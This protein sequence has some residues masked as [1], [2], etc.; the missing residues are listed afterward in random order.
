M[1][2]T[3]VRGEFVLKGEKS[4]DM[5]ALIEEHLEGLRGRS[6]Y[7]LAQQDSGKIGTPLQPTRPDGRQK[8]LHSSA[9][10]VLQKIPRS[11]FVNEA[12]CCWWRG[13][14]AR[15]LTGTG[16]EPPTRGPTAAAPSTG[17][18]CCS[19]RLSVDPLKTCWYLKL[20]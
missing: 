4:A 9:L 8:Q 7:A 3:T 12:T 15:L 10:L 18:S 19:F 14:T 1:S 17:T 5:A 20:T 6:A 13:R 11:W 16:S 2:L